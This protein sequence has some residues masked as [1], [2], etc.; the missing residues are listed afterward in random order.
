MA[1]MAPAQSQWVVSDPGAYVR[2]AQ[3]IAQDVQLVAAARQELTQL[4]SSLFSATN[5]S[6]YLNNSATALAQAQALCKSNPSQCNARARVA[7]AQAP[8]LQRIV[9]NLAS[10]RNAAQGAPGQV[11]ATQAVAAATVHLGEQTAAILQRNAAIDAEQAAA[12]A[13]VYGVKQQ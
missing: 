11:A 4:P 9:T 12:N 1:T 5:L 10:I 2:A 13:E 7:L 6:G 3:Q 8:A